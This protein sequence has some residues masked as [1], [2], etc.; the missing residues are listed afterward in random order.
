ML[1]QFEKSPLGKASASPKKKAKNVNSSAKKK[2]KRADE[3]AGEGVSPS[4][5]SSPM[6]QA[7]LGFGSKSPSKQ[8]MRLLEHQGDTPDCDDEISPFKSGGK[9]RDSILASFD[10]I[11][12]EEEDDNL[13]RT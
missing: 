8:Q 3:N 1:V 12:F 2:S 5:R 6:K 7:A 13:L 4:K 10:K 11:S 9:Q